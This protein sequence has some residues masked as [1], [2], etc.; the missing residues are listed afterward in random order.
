MSAASAAA[1][2]CPCSSSALGRHECRSARPRPAIGKSVQDLARSPTRP[3]DLR[4]RPIAFRR[5]P[6]S[7]CKP[8]ASRAARARARTRTQ[9]RTRDLRPAPA[10]PQAPPPTSMRLGRCYG[11]CEPK[12]AGPAAG[13]VWGGCGGGLGLGACGVG[14][15]AP[16]I[17]RRARHASLAAPRRRFARRRALLAPL[18]SNPAGTPAPASP[19]AAR[20]RGSRRSRRGGTCSWQRPAGQRRPRTGA[21]R[22]PA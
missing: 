22:R 3:L 7:A 14:C 17:C 16:T 20:G 4:T 19:Q 10:T 12:G 13:G 15:A 9:T 21:R 1:A 11:S 2:Q 5:S 6:A 18:P 8:V